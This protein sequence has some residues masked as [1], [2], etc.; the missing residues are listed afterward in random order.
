MSPAKQQT[1]HQPAAA[2]HFKAW[3]VVRQEVVRAIRAN[4]SE[5]R[6]RTIFPTSIYIEGY[7]GPG[8]TT[9]TFKATWRGPEPLTH[10]VRIALDKDS[11]NPAELLRT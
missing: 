2:I 7:P 11:P 4:A 3:P 8:I 6:A 1:K 10:R 5:E 9:A